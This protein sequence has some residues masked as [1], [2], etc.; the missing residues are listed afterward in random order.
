MCNMVL[1]SLSRRMIVQ[2]VRVSTQ[3][4]A[5]LPPQVAS[6][7]RKR[8]HAAVGNSRIPSVATTRHGRP[9]QTLGRNGNSTG[10]SATLSSGTGT[11]GQRY[12]ELKRPNLRLRTVPRPGKPRGNNR[13]VDGSVAQVVVKPPAKQIHFHQ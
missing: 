2:L 7:S 6:G 5:P 4:L 10:P 3:E 9:D 1:Y 13:P 12:P 11:V 8:R